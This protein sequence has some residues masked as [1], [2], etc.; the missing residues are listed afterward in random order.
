MRVIAAL[1]FLTLAVYSSSQVFGYGRCPDVRPVEDFDVHRYAG[2]WYEIARFYASAEQ[3]LRC[4]TENYTVMDGYLLSNDSGIDAS[5]RVYSHVV[6]IYNV[7]EWNI[8]LLYYESEHPV[9]YWVP[10]VDYESY[11]IN[12][13]CKEY[14]RGL[15]NV[16]NTWIIARDRKMSEEDYDD[17]MRY[18]NS[19]GINTMKL[20]KAEQRNCRDDH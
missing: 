4:E 10:F 8:G 6:K 2:R 5:G 12:Y 16:Q 15:I 18:L 14:L 19:V 9:K 20:E 11:S 17:V 1:I 13:V 3:G 7:S